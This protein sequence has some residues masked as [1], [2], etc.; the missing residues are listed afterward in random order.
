MKIEKEF[1]TETQRTLRETEKK[2]RLYL[3]YKKNNVLIFYYLLIP[4]SLC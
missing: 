1:T 3:E 2:N 4:V